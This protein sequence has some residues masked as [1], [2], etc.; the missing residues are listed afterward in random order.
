M[1]ESPPALS[2]APEGEIKYVGGD[3]SLDL[4]NT[5]NWLEDGL[6]DDRL[7]DY[8]RVVQWAEGAGITSAR[9]ADALRQAAAKRPRQAEEVLEAARSLRWLLR[10]VFAAVARG[11]EPGSAL[12]AFNAALGDSLSRLTV[13]LADARERDGGAMRWA[14]RGMGVELESPLWPV[15]RSAAELLVAEEPRQ[16]RICA[17]RACGWMFVDRSR[18]G[19]RRWCDMA[20]CGTRE[21]SRRRRLRSRR[22][23]P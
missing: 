17:G 7:S 2:Y 11:E 21:K 4:I 15:I 23:G 12:E 1:R 14:W 8:A 16:I 18:N 3:P 22:K 10:R 6:I 20:T 9:D 13:G 19:L 5:V